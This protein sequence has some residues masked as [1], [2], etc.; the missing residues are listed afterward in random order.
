MRLPEK[1]KVLLGLYMNA[2]TVLKCKHKDGKCKI[3]DL[4]LLRMKVKL[5][6]L[7]VGD[8]PNI[9]NCKEHPNHS[10]C[11]RKLE[12]KLNNKD[13]KDKNEHL[14]RVYKRVRY[15]DDTQKVKVHDW[16]IKVLQ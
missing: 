16:K 14:C 4:N 15:L 2:A 8:C 6:K 10:G 12:F 3:K 1:D 7:N 11:I 9:G 13:E 5:E